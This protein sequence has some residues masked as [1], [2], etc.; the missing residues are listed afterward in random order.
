MRVQFSLLLVFVFACTE[1]QPA[2][3]VD[4]NPSDPESQAPDGGESPAPTMYPEPGGWGPTTGFGA[5]NLGF[6]DDELFQNC[7][8][9]DG[10]IEDVL[11]HHNL[12][13]MYD[14]YLLMPWSPETGTGA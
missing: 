6:A 4:E 1:G 7:A 12:V 13:T 10:G 2:S 14:G 11:D 9:L 3:A 8:F 5:P